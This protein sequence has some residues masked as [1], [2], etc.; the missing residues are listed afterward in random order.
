MERPDVIN[1]L[2]Y[3]YLQGTTNAY[4]RSENET[5]AHKFKAGIGR[6]RS[7]MKNNVL[8]YVLDALLIS[9][10]A[11]IKN[12]LDDISENWIKF[13]RDISRG[14]FDWGSFNNLFGL[15]KNLVAT[16]TKIAGALALITGL[17]GLI[18]GLQPLLGF[19]AFMGSIAMFGTFINFCLN[20][21][22]AVMNLV[23]LLL[24]KYKGNEKLKIQSINAGKDS[25]WGMLKNGIA[26]F[27]FGLINIIPG[28]V[29]DTPWDRL[30]SGALSSDSTNF[31][32]KGNSTSTF[33]AAVRTEERFAR[34][35]L[36]AFWAEM[37]GPKD[38]NMAREAREKLVRM[39]NRL[40][41]DNSGLRQ[42]VSARNENSV[43]IL[44]KVNT[45]ELIRNFSDV[46]PED[47]KE[48]LDHKDATEGTLELN[49]AT[50]DVA[51]LVGR[52]LC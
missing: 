33:S 47:E 7:A 32:A 27:T 4:A 43:N 46:V 17:L 30:D 48:N 52:I 42:E 1:K 10:I 31:S 22:Q 26:F 14:P 9:P 44:E 20:T 49:Q 3:L 39:S 37:L 21:L 15:L 5:R 35:S 16:V 13:S 2:Y 34:G 8:G 36:N 19:A 28:A 12:S 25:L 6:I 51:P 23:T 38:R 24:A 11:G 18:P 45:D 50:R 29:S 41:G 40:P